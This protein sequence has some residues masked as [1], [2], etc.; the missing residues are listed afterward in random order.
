MVAGLSPENTFTDDCRQQYGESTF[1]R[2]DIS[3]VRFVN[4]TQFSNEAIE[5]GLLVRVERP[6]TN[7]PNG[8]RRAS[9]KIAAS[10]FRREVQSDSGQSKRNPGRNTKDEESTIMRTNLKHYVWAL[11]IAGS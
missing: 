10:P 7:R 5:V 4:R 3:A 6:L 1:A 9:S 11:A 8:H 2:L